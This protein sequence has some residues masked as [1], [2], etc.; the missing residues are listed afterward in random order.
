MIDLR[1][2]LPALF[3]IPLWFLSILIGVWN[4]RR[5]NSFWVGFLLSLFLTPVG[6]AFLI[7]TTTTKKVDL[8]KKKEHAEKEASLNDAYPLTEERPQ[9]IGPRI[10]LPLAGDFE[11]SVEQA[12]SCQYS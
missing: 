9:V 1:P 6:G 11:R 8:V 2:L 7:A 4:V 12:A 5:G 10:C 3:P